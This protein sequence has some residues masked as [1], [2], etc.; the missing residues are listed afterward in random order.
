M[1]FWADTL[2]VL[3]V[4]T[5]LRVLGASRLST[6]IRTVA[7]QGALLGLLPVLAHLDSLSLRLFLQAGASTVLKAAVFPW[8]LGK[9]LREAGIQREVEPFVGFSASLGAGV[10]FLAAALWLGARLPLAG[11]E[12]LW[13]L[14][15]TALF[16][17]F[18][19][20]FVIVSR[21]KAVTQVLGYLI[22][23]NGIYTF[24]M[25]FAEKQPLLVELGILLDV[26]MAVFVMGITIYHINR[27]FDH[28]DA[29]RM[30]ALKD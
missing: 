4:L 21:R 7:F 19:G 15:P 27:E 13:H 2:I 16:T 24:G 10:L 5:N 20:L 9:A 12:P 6:C 26:F 29:D 25:A 3:V 1:R 30:T 14:A 8:L 18:T 11:S 17:I 28:L 23:E 22:L